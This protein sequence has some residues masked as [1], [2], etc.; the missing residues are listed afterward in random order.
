MKLTE[1]VSLF[2][3]LRREW[4]YELLRSTLQETGSITA[5]AAKLGLNRPSLH[6]RMKRLG[7][8]SP[9][10]TNRGNWGGLTN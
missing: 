8:T 10:P 2:Y 7:V 5:T 1:K 4:E 6:G 3:R 9:K